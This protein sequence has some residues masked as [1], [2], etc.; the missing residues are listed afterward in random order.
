MKTRLPLLVLLLAAFSAPPASA[1]P[2][3]PPVQVLSQ[4]CGNFGPFGL[5]TPVGGFTTGCSRRFA[6]KLGAALGPDGNFILLDYP[7]CASGACAGQTGPAGISCHALSG[8]ACCLSSSQTVNTIQGTNV[9]LL[10][11]G[12]A[13]RI[14]GDSDARS[15]ICYSAYAGDGRRVV[16]VPLITLV[17]ANT[18]ARLDGFVQ[19]FLTSPPTGTAQSTTFTVEF[20]S[21]DATPARAGT[22][23]RIKTIYR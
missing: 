21:L 7:V 18:A 17:F 3:A 15:G 23:G 6:L 1:A 12:L 9:G 8:Y 19:V 4:L 10:A 11:A 5:L 2:G 22:W 13:S 14:S 20:I 16:N